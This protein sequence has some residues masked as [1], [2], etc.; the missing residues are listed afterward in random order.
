[1]TLPKTLR[2]ATAA[3]GK[4]LREALREAFGE[5]PGKRLREV[6]GRTL[7]AAFGAALCALLAAG[8][9]KPAPYV[10][11][12]G[13]MLGT[14]MHVVADFDPARRA[15][16]YAAAMAL[17]AE[18]KASM[19]L[20]DEGS[21]LSRLNRNETD[22]VDRHIAFNLALADSVGA[23]SGGY[24][25]ATVAP[26]VEAWGFAGRGRE[27]APDV[28]SL[29]RFVGRTKVRVEAGRLRKEDPRVRLDFN[30][31]AKGYTVDLLAAL[32]ER[33]GARNYIVD[34]GGEVR[35]RGVNRTGGAWRVGIE[36]PFDGNMTEGEYLQRRLAM[37]EGGL[38]TSGNY[39]RFYVDAGGNKVAHTID[40]HTGRSALSRLLSVTVW[41]PTC[42]EADALGTMFLSMGDL[43]ARA[44]LDTMPAVRAYF[45]LAGEGGEYE[46]YV[47]PA[48]R[49]L[50][51]E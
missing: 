48:M 12:D 21:L 27:E 10:E 2:A 16:F 13:A 11:V 40:P 14:R 25:D 33:F 34:I 19:S 29:L 15:E 5:A 23:L 44:A 7:R 8:C 49:G 32:A 46:E 4:M 6:S 9:R 26:L 22:S 28:D 37:P 35:C 43:R 31:V 45:I 38:A 41:A 17:D 3:P 36:T 39:R 20:F 47:S 30:S 42:A 51:M 18:A 50:I 1:M 24:Y